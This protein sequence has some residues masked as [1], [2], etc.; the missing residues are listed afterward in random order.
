MLRAPVV[1]LVP[2]HPRSL[3]MITQLSPFHVHISVVSSMIYLQ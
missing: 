1:Q 2:T 3:Y